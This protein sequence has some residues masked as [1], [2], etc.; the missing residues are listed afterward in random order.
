MTRRSISFYFQVKIVG[1]LA[2]IDEGETDWKLVAIDIEDPVAPQIND[3]ADVE[4][5]FPGL[6]K[7]STI[8]EVLRN[9]SGMSSEGI[10]L[11]ARSNVLLS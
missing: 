7:V 10:V 5:H 11:K 8:L 2:L 6:L 3:I 1:T 9:S 4:K